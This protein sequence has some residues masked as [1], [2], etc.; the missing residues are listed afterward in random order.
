MNIS[1]NDVKNFIE[2]ELKTR[3]FE[4]LSLKEFRIVSEADLQS[5]VYLHLRTY[6][7]KDPR[8]KIYNKLY[9]S[10]P[11][12]NTGIFPDIVIQRNQLRAK[13]AIELKENRS[14]DI[15]RA[16]KDSRKLS[17]LG[18]MEHGY[19]IYLTRQKDDHGSKKLTEICLQRIPSRYLKKVTPIVINAF[20]KI[21]KK[22]WTRWDKEWQKH[23]KLR[24]RSR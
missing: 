3:I 23:S 2:N 17:K 12:K 24:I 21:P 9:L 16:R 4:E 14:L 7:N 18:R 1:S 19:L 5:I 10:K 15:K 22:E 6:L 8:W 13:I 20:D 11:G